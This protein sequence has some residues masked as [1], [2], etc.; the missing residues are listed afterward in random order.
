MG[1]FI[2]GGMLMDLETAIKLLKK[3]VKPAGT[4]D[5]NHID[6]NLVSAEERPIYEKALIVAQLAVSEGKLGRDELM[7]RLNL[8]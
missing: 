8:G 1:L 7:S 6:L 3:V 5:N 4:V 2:F